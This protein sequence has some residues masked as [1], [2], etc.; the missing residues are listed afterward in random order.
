MRLRSGVIQF[1][2]TIIFSIAIIHNKDNLRGYVACSYVIRDNDSTG[3]VR[4]SRINHDVQT[5]NR[6]P[7]NRD[8]PPS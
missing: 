5:R 8:K 6:L 4:R 1:R 2:K 3:H 7:V